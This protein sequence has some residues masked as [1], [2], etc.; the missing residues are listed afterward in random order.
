M[1][2]IQGH[3][4]VVKLAIFFLRDFKTI[5]IYSTVGL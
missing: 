4:D 3:T 1:K 2:K 5:N